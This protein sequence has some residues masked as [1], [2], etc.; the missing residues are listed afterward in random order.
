MTPGTQSGMVQAPP[1]HPAPV[2]DDNALGIHSLD[3]QVRPSTINRQRSTDCSVALLTGCA[4]KPYALGLAAA[5]TSRGLAI[6]FIGSD[7]INGPELQDNPRVRFLNLRGDQRSDAGRVAKAI[8]ILRYYGRLIRYAA[9]AKPKI[10][11]ILWNNKF[12]LFD[13]TALMLFYKLLGKKL[14][15]TAH[16][17]NAGKRDA[18]DGWL[19]RCS[20]RFQYWSSDHIFIHTEKMKI[21]LLSEFGVPERKATVIP[22][23]INSTVP[24]TALATQAAKRQLGVDGSDK[25]LLFFGNIAPYKGLE[26]LVAAFIELAR[27]NLRY[28]LIIAGNPKGSVDY[29]NQISQTISQNGIQDRI[30][31]RIEFVPD[32]QTEL[33]FKAADVLILP[34]THIF[35]SG[36]LSL[37]YNFG[38]P[39]IAANVGSLKEEIIEGRT[40]FV[41]PAKDSA[42]LAR[43][44][45]TYFSTGLFEN[46]EHRRQEIREYANE[47][48][49]WAKVAAL[50]AKVYS[51]L[52]EN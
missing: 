47:R 45:E 7:Q 21:E 6:D 25:T 29:W 44:I 8:R 4:D 18:N 50:T 51:E 28:R 30:I 41:F 33:Y 49:S 48:Y 24:R 46:L 42:A 37:A 15:F 23:G 32:E 34:Y 38:L 27:K 43:A 31:E 26:Y 13:R 14:V 36:V 52:Q 40:G 11:H 1:S 5:L 9:T 22:F 12:E 17:V 35:Q 16:N 10:F 2:K 20:L 19:N 3:S 39:V